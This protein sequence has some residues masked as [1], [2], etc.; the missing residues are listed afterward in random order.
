MYRG[1]KDDKSY[2]KHVASLFGVFKAPLKRSFKE[3]IELIVKKKKK[4]MMPD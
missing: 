4:S 3:S 1:G 2:L